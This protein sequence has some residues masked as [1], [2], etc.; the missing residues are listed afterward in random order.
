M[1]IAFA[2]LLVVQMH[3]IFIHWLAVGELFHGRSRVCSYLYQACGERYEGSSKK[4]EML[5]AVACQLKYVRAKV[6]CPLLWVYV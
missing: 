4:D 5:L 6:N 2:T 3:W 1:R